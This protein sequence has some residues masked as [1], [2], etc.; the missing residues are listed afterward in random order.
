MKIENLNDGYVK[1]YRALKRKND[2]SAPVNAKSWK[3]LEYVV[4]LAYKEMSKRDQDDQFA[5]SIGRKLSLKVKTRLYEDIDKTMKVVRG[6]T[7]YAIIKI[8]YDRDKD[9]MY[10]YME[11]ERTIAQGDI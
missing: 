4:E 10:L 1:V 9:I 6:N 11:E 2:F 5:Q 8:D 7:L 3:D